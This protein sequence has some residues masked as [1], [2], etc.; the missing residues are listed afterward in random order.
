MFVQQYNNQLFNLLLDNSYVYKAIYC[1]YTAMVK[2]VNKSTI[3]KN[4]SVYSN[5]TISDGCMV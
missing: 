5:V 2:Q 1:V 4:V 3:Y